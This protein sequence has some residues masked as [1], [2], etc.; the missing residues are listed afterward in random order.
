MYGGDADTNGAVAGALMGALCG[1]KL[2]PTEWRDGMRY[3][4]WYRA[5]IAA[6]CSVAGLSDE[7]YDSTSDV[8]TELDGGK[9]FISEEEIKRR[10]TAV[11]AKVYLADMERRRGNSDAEVVTGVESNSAA[12][13]ALISDALAD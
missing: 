8:D 4:E 2:L 7:L 1:Y 13:K 6:L 12:W 3:Q 5:K 10:E 11:I 9:G